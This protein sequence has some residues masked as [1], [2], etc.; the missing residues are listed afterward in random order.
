MRHSIAKHASN[1]QRKDRKIAK[2]DPTW[3][4]RLKKDPGIPNLFPYKEKILQE[5]E[6]KK[7]LKEQ[8]AIRRRE[9]TRAR[10]A[11]LAAAAKG[12]GSAAESNA[13]GETTM[14]EE[15]DVD[16]DEDMDVVGFPTRHL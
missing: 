1:K 14:S 12:V 5:I 11:A 9:E 15:E 3:R 13:E 8:E 2:K 7:S 6:E 16:D 10:N 4:S